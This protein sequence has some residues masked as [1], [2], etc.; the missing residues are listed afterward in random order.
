MTEDQWVLEDVV[1]INDNG[2]IVGYGTKNEDLYHGFL[3]IPKTP[4]ADKNK[5]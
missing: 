4:K 2:L 1:D 5:K 3:L